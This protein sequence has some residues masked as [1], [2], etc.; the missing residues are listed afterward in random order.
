MSNEPQPPPTQTDDRLERFLVWMDGLRGSLVIAGF[1]ALVFLWR[2]AKDLNL[3]SAMSI[4]ALLAVIGAEIGRRIETRF[5]G[6]K[7]L[8]VKGLEVL[9]LYLPLVILAVLMRQILT[10]LGSSREVVEGSIGLMY[11]ILLR[12]ALVYSKR[13]G[14]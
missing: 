8:R 9:R 4:C 1:A 6:S 12:G 2:G 14:S 11:G 5:L 10:T 7:T 3:L 13:W